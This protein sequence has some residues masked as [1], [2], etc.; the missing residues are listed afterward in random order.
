MK[1]NKGSL[2]ITARVG[3][4]FKPVCHSVHGRGG[5]YLPTM[6]W[7]R[8]TASPEGNPLPPPPP[9]DMVNQRELRILLECIF[10]R[11]YEQITCLF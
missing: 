4:V 7:G 5:F 9:P 2:L 3:N 11:F 8:H 1:I 6:P 10:H